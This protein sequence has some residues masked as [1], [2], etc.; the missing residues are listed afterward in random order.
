MMPSGARGVSAKAAAFA[1][2]VVA[3]VLTACAGRT[4]GAGGPDVPPWARVA[5]EGRDRTRAADLPSPLRFTAASGTTCSTMRVLGH[6]DRLYVFYGTGTFV[7]MYPDETVLDL[8][9]PARPFGPGLEGAVREV[10]GAW[11]GSLWIRA[12]TRDGPAAYYRHTGE[13]WQ[14]LDAEVGGRV[15]HVAGWIGDSAL[16]SW[17]CGVGARCPPEGLQLRAFGATPAPQF[18]AL[19]PVWPAETCR[20]GYEFT[21]ASGGEIVASGQFCHDR[22]IV[23]TE[24]W[25]AVLWS[26]T[27]GT[28]IDVLT[29]KTSRKW[30][31]GPV[32]AL[33]ADRVFATATFD[34]RFESS[35]APQLR[36]IVAAFDG[37]AWRLLPTVAGR[38][39]RFDVD[40]DGAPW[41]Q[42]VDGVTSRLLRHTPADG[43]GRLDFLTSEPRDFGGLRGGHAWVIEAAGPT[44]VR[45]AGGTFARLNLPPRPGSDEPSVPVTS[46]AAADGALWLT[47]VYETRVDWEE[48]L[49]RGTACVRLLRSGGE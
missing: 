35:E 38:L 15:T 2:A 7:R 41:L 14:K 18:P 47:G 13:A 16:A 21:T 33:A 36:T 32:V 19:Q 12:G 39:E 42:V 17:T 49:P 20:T 30:W 27:G 10:V 46:F 31:P 8:S 44:W 11:G 6:A 3:A 9:I 1:V 24:P 40:G 28:R 25:Y 48:Q 34:T 5:R 4:S 23:G 37:T 29:R 45:P 22:A 26:P 43:W